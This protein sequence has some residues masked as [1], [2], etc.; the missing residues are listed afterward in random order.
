MK[1]IITSIILGLLMNY[2]AFAFGDKSTENTD[3]SNASCRGSDSLDGFC[4]GERVYID[5]NDDGGKVLSVKI[6]AIDHKLQE[7]TTRHEDGRIF[8]RLSSDQL[9]KTTA[10]LCGARA[11]IGDRFINIARDYRFVKIV[12]IRIVKNEEEEYVLYYEDKSELGDRWTRDSLA[13][14]KSGECSKDIC[15]GDRAYLGSKNNRVMQVAGVLIDGNI[16]VFIEDLVKQLGVKAYFRANAES[17]VVFERAQEVQDRVAAETLAKSGVLDF[18]L[19]KSLKKTGASQVEALQNAS[20]P[21]FVEIKDTEKFLNKLAEHVYKFDGS[22]LQQIAA[23]TGN[24]N[25]LNINMRNLF[26]MNALAP[27]LRNYGYANIREK[28]LVPSLANLDTVNAQNH[29]NGLQDFDATAMI[30]RLSLQILSISLLT[31]K[32]QYNDL[33]NVEAQKLLQIISSALATNLRHNDMNSFYNITA[34]FENFE[35]SLVQNA[36]LKA[37]A[38]SDMAILEFLKNNK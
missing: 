25:D 7:F 5:E 37:R 18:E 35:L 28:F 31:A 15:V 29:I 4:V 27:A 11:C 20:G 1:N 38:T 34:E 23:L 2:T 30:R 32:P 21:V 8:P 16:V 13:S 6:E 17:F 12:G 33:Q 19:Y 14:T 3:Q 26:I 9:W 10:G 22:Y 36:Y 24:D